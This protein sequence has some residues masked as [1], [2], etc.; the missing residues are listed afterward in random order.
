MKYLNTSIRHMVWNI[1][2]WF[3]RLIPVLPLRLNYTD[4]VIMIK[5]NRLIFPI[6]PTPITKL[7]VYS[8]FQWRCWISI[9]R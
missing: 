1:A 6:L 2:C 9:L 3:V 7:T 8:R 4:A 5:M